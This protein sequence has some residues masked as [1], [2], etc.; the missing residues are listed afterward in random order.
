MLATL[1]DVQGD[2]GV[3]R[4]LEIST[5]SDG[6]RWSVAIPVHGC[7]DLLARALA[8]VVAQVGDRDD[9]EILVVDDACSDDVQK[10]VTE[11]GRGRVQYHRNVGWLGAAGT[12]NRC[13][14]LTRG[15]LVHILHGD[16]AV[17]PGFYAALESAMSDHPEAVAAMC[18][19][20]YIDR[21][22]TCGPVSRRYREGT[23]IWDGALRSVAVSNRVRPP[24]IAV[25]RA[26][27]DRVG[28]FRTDLPHAADWE[29][30]VRLLASGP[31]VFVDEVLA[32]YRRHPDQDTAGRVRSGSNIRERADAIPCVTQHVSPDER[33]RLARKALLYSS[34]FA[35]RTAVNLVRAHEWAVAGVQVR[36]AA[37]CLAKVPMGVPQTRP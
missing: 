14:E 22:D 30:W 23:G 3:A 36:E 8:E 15:D 7:I 34:V 4:G 21:D 6:V 20:Q 29:M 31:L 32:C 1:L 33:E 5:R 10:V 25:R 17:L 37:R 35:T 26:A 16:D 28:G 11:L 27:Y 18:R 12:F 13:L 24:S 2:G 19:T 9:A